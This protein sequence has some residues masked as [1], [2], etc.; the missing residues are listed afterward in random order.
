MYQRYPLIMNHPAHTHARKIR[1]ATP[2]IPPAPGRPLVQAQ[3]EQ[4]EPEKWAPVTVQN[5]D[6]EAQHA[7]KGY[8]AAGSPNPQAFEK[9]FASPHVPGQV[10][11]EWPKMVDGVLVQDP[12]RVDPNAK[13]EYP[14]WVKVPGGED[15]LVQ[16]AEE[17]SRYLERETAPSRPS[18]AQL[19]QAALDAA[20][21]F[22]SEDKGKRAKQNKAA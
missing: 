9:A 12:N 18:D 21:A 5:E 1:D 13:M 20:R 17:E 16:S 2:A 11:S 22:D 6:Q 8:V 15:I 19:L 14:K 3:P 4:W 7:A 10:N